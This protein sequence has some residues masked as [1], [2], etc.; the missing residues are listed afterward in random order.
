MN[1]KT[2]VI[3]IAA[4]A[5]A[6]VLPLTA[7]AV[8]SVQVGSAA[9]INPVIGVFPPNTTRTASIFGTAT[10]SD[11][12]ELA[13]ALRNNPDLIYDYIRNNVETVWMYGLQKGAVG[14]II[15]KSGTPFDQAQLM[16]RLLKE[17]GYPSAAYQVGTITLNGTQFQDWTGITNAAA[18]CQLLSSGGVPGSVNGS[19][20]VTDCTTIAGSVTTVVMAHAWVSVKIPD[21]GSSTYLFDPSYKPHTF[22]TG[23]NLATAASLTSGQAMTQVAT[24]MTSGTASTVPYVVNLG[25]EALNTTLQGYA[26][27]LL[28]QI[29]TNYQSA[30]IED[31]VG[32][33]A[34]TPFVAPPGGLRQTSLPYTANALRTWTSTNDVPDIY[35]TSLR[36]VGTKG[37]CT[38]GGF[39]QIFDQLLYAD[40]IYARRLTLGGTFTISGD[41]S[42]VTLE[43]RDQAGAGV[44]LFS[45]VYTC[46][47]GFNVGQ[48]T[49]TVNHPYPASADGSTGTAGTYMDMTTTKEVKYAN[50]LTIV[51][52]WGDVGRGF[53]DKIG[54]RIDDVLPPLVTSGCEL[55]VSM[56]HAQSGAARREQLTASWLAQA[57]EA[58]RL[59]AAIAK[60]IYSHHH[61]IGVVAGETEV[62]AVC[63]FPNCGTPDF[64][65]TIADSFD[66]LDIDSGISL[67]SKTA[68]A[69]ARRAAVHAIAATMDSLEASTSAQT[70]D[71][72][73]T[74]ST[75]TRFEW[76]NRPP[77]SED[78]APA[79]FSGSPRRFYEFTSANAAQGPSLVKVEAQT[80]TTDDGFH[81]P[82]TPEIG[83]SEFS[84]R[85]SRLTNA[86][87]SYASAGFKIVAS[88]EA[89]LGP[90]QR[91]G[92]FET[93]G[94]PANSYKHRW[95]K[96]R[97][98]AFVATR[99]SAGGEPLEIAHVTVGPDNTSKGGGGGAQTGH[100]AQYDPSVAADVL[101][102]RFVDRS[103]V[104][105]VDMLNGAVTAQSPASITVGNGGF[106]YE[107]SANLIWTGGNARS[108]ALGPVAHSEPQ[109]PWTT[110]WNNTLTVSGS[111]LEMM[112]EGDIRATAGTIAAF[113]AAQDAYK[114]TVS[115]QREVAGALINAWWVKQ[116]T[117]S[118]VTVNV[119]A[120]T[121]QFVKLVD[122]SWIAP[123]AG[124]H[125][126]LTQTGARTIYEEPACGG[127]DV[128]YVTTRGWS[129]SSVSF[130]V[131]NA[132]GD[133]QNFSP[134]ASPFTD[135]GSYCAMLRGFRLSSWV[136]PQNVT[137]NLVYTVP[138]GVTP[139]QVPELSEV[140]NSLGRKIVFVKSG[141][142][143]F[144]NGLTA[145]DLRSVT[146]TGDPAA[147]GTITHTEPNGSVD[148][149]T[150]TIVGE[151]YLLTHI[152]T[153]E[154]GTTASTKYDY[155]A[156][157]RVKEARD[158][159]ALQGPDPRGPYQFFL[160]DG[161]R[162]ER[163]DPAGAAYT[164][165]YNS[166][167]RPFGFMD[168]LGRT[169]T[170]I[171]DGRGRVTS[172]I[173]PEGDR[174]VFKYDARNN[175]T[176][177]A[178]WPKGCTAEPCTP[179][180]L[181]VKAAWHTTW[182]K[183]NWIDD[184][185]GN[186][187]DFAYY[188]SGNGAS[189]VQTATR[190]AAAAGGTRPVY[191]FTYNT[192][193]K[194][195]TTTDPTGL[196]VSNTY[197]PT[198]HDLLT[199]T[200]DP[201]AAPHIAAVT[202]YA[203]DTLGD[204]SSATDP[205]LN[206]TE[207]KY[208]NN[209]RKT[210]TLHH[211]GNIA[212]CLVSAEK[213][214]YD[215][216][217]RVTFEYG[218]TAFS[219]CTTVTTWQTL[220]SK[221]Y[222]KTGKVL[223]EANGA[224]NTTTYTYDAMDRVFDVDDP[225]HRHTRFEYTLAG[226][227]LREIR[228][229]GTALQQDYATYTYT[230]NGQ[231]AT[232]KDANNNKSTLEYDGFDRLIKQ[233]FPVPTLGG[234]ASSTTDYEQY[235]YDNNGN[236][237]SMRTRDA[238][239]IAY[240]YD[241]LNRETLKDIPGGTPNDVYSDYDLVGR[242]I[243]K[244]FGSTGGQGIDYT[245]DSAKR[246]A[247]ETSFGRTLTFDYDKS[248]N[249]IKLTYPD[250][251]Y[252]SYDFDAVSR[253]TQVRENSTTV[254]TGVLQ[255]YAWDPLS[256]RSATTPLSRGNGTMTSYG[257]DTA[258]RLTSL[259]H[260][261][262]GTTFDATLGFGYTAASQLNTRSTTNGA[263]GWWTAPN[264]VQ[265]YAVN[266][267]N[268]YITVNGTTYTHDARGNL[269]SDGS[270]TFAYDVE[271][272]L[273]SVSGSASM[274]LT[275]DPL[276]RLRQTVAGTTTTQFVYDGDRLTMEYN[277]SNAIVRRYVHGS[278]ADEPIVWYEG[279]NL[280][281]KRWL[282]QD[283]RGSVIAHTNSSGT[284]TVYNYGPYGE[285]PSWSGS[286]FRYT[287]QIMLSEVQLY[288]YKARVYDPNIGRFLQTDPIGYK[289]DLNLYAYV[290]NDPLDETDST[291][292]CPNCFTAAIGAV[293]GAVGGVL[294]QAGTDL[295]TGK[296]SSAADYAGAFVGGGTAGAVLGFTGNPILAG[297]AGG[298]AGNAVKQGVENVTGDR[299]GFSG[300]ELG[301]AAAIGGVTGGVL[302]GA[303]LKVPGITSGRYSFAA[304][305]KAI[306]TKL[307][308]GSIENVSGKTVAKGATAKF[309]DDLGRSALTAAGTG[310][311][312]VAAEKVDA[313]K[314]AVRSSL[315]TPSGSPVSS[316]LTGTICGK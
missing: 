36:V 278:G 148:K 273:T 171:Y 216:L 113:I 276:G 264:N 168:E 5:L 217:G 249:R 204:T 116:L 311:A 315:S 314:D 96:Q 251:N 160:A 138:N 89:F 24:G 17:A 32:G 295:I 280:T 293:A 229:Y 28:T 118:I 277:G 250:A 8:P 42:T 117:G 35:R 9:L 84:W 238:Q 199:S 304:I 252:I 316:C 59:H 186:R 287:G 132:S 86:I 292:E 64:V 141:R 46:N 155:D 254:G 209:R 114:A 18:A 3:A 77:T 240:S 184:A 130:A 258:S 21:N 181:K 206:L 174:E 303:G 241:N 33:A 195:L 31:L 53:I 158:A 190:P 140:N 7:G 307:T 66:R 162:G 237:T 69:V 294:V 265:S 234:N 245:Y 80:S 49:L 139:M 200:L 73:D 119:G 182:N 120:G 188:A 221:T 180:A 13:R 81:G 223:T 82:A 152:F 129:Y 136:F 275:Y 163:V 170:A 29:N 124:P 176:E 72:P 108:T 272:R 166:R 284:A 92:A 194:V 103:N 187:T 193:G 115:P 218:A 25:S 167:K 78:P 62:K 146:V 37:S 83:S 261:V 230:L 95:S 70:S 153:A 1:S 297:A 236:R 98:G 109:Q 300:S 19:T 203:Y 131:T 212:G 134:W 299:S 61:S 290:R 41:T 215:V 10:P 145:G 67:T 99:Y 60:S 15:D 112:G 269:T 246:L 147:A 242:P 205:R 288:H 125:A 268:Q 30:E 107:L 197:D 165:F 122:G 183:P 2:C 22:K 172:Y 156:L 143:G 313:V 47:P 196:V 201:G 54:T 202:T 169:T 127:G 191:S 310:A 144:N 88:E 308:R 255:T 91:A 262:A 85:M 235:D 198:T 71:L 179:A 271:N 296:V 52:G 87:S 23:I 285:Q 75:A 97:S 247:T 213:T 34:I 58:A 175:P 231:R 267:L 243:F 178:K 63:K 208:D 232:I 11:I 12:A 248:G 283:E 239:M 157:R 298:A 309:V 259:G 20:N 51:H 228:A 256:R 111:G 177:L 279:A 207:F 93:Q 14:A 306:Q 282:H 149:Y 164:I 257:Y 270:R 291:G 27:N 274:T 192:R 227:T 79:P 50:R 26:T 220:N 150:V 57:S 48:L 210:Q 68:D 302:K 39:P 266:G 102:S 159:V 289:D 16:V 123:G 225:V 142:G 6:T 301:K 173:Y 44:N 65:Y 133:I 135:G 90:G 74:S 286:R 226:E 128:T 260:D 154:N 76:G 4:A 151:K 312:T 263:L 211:I 222:T 137:I 106:P 253:M 305:A 214:D 121:R 43:V 233:R 126:T 281:D 56:F 40:D 224:G 105:G 219:P 185:K 101:K 100:Q 244:R 45:Q 38:V 104:L 55:C 189:L 161:V 110:N 94:A